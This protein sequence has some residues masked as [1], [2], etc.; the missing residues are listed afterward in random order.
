M[1]SIRILPPATKNIETVIGIII[2]SAPRSGCKNTSITGIIMETINGIKPC[3]VSE[4]VCLCRAQKEATV[5]IIES[6]RNSVGCRAK[7][8]PG[9]SN[10]HRA[11]LILIPK[12]KTP[13]SII[14]TT[15]AIHFAYFFHHI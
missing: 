1:V 8:S 5:R 13:M 11:P 15:V 2:K 6:L 3:C 12:I 7:G 14:I 4:S 10:H 9:R